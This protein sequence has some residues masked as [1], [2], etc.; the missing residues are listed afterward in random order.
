MN[1]LKKRNGVPPWLYAV[2][3]FLAGVLVGTLGLI[4]LAWLVDQEL[5]R[6]G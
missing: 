6:Q 5:E 1:T 3:G 4:G 2:G